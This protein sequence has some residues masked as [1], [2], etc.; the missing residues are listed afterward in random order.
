MSD[1]M[2][3]NATVTNNRQVLRWLWSMVQPFRWHMVVLLWVPVAWATGLSLSSYVIQIMVARITQKDPFLVGPMIF[4]IAIRLILMASYRLYDWAISVRMIPQ[5]RQ[6]IG[7][8]IMNRLFRKAYPYFQDNPS[9]SLTAKINDL[10]RNV[11]NLIELITQELFGN[12]LAVL[13]AIATLCS[14]QPVFGLLMGAWAFLIIVI[15][16]FSAKHFIHIA[17]VW[18]ECT[19]ELTGKKVDI[20][21]NMLLIRLFGWR[22][23]EQTHFSKARV[24]PATIEQKMERDYLILRTWTS[25]ISG[26]FLVL[27]GWY[28]CR[29]YAKGTIHAGGFTLVLM[30]NRSVMDFLWRFDQFFSNASEYYGSIAQAIQTIVEKTDVCA[31]KTP[32]KPDLCITRG[33]IVFSGVQFAYPNSAPLLRDFSVRIGAGE[34]VGIV[35]YSGSGKTTLVHILLRLYPMQKGTI[36]IDGQDIQ[37]MNLSSLYDQITLVP[38]DPSLFH[39]SL[40]DNIL[41]ANSAIGP[42]DLD[43]ALEKACVRDFVQNLPQGLDTL[44]GERGVKLSGGQR[45]RIALARALVRSTPIVILDESTSQLDS[46]TESKIHTHLWEFCQNKT[47]LII[48]HRLS[49]LQGMDR[50]LVFDQGQIVQEGTHK[51]LLEKDGLYARFW[52]NQ[53][54]VTLD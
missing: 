10:K 54:H 51:A 40:R 13:I 15:S 22:Q 49:T 3:K 38:Q 8:D 48:A 53:E 9:G 32:T 26:V 35:G 36:T 46:V 30:V 29:G 33:E 23:K 47:V 6:G 31:Q 17:H 41:Y 4:F 20:L 25:V 37:N 50:I 44:V 5:L 43:C 19:A 52:H 27:N 12:T 1:Q 11:P 39:M 42:A 28:L 45:Q 2:A 21:G 24:A 18:S 14:V 34:K 16:W 7:A